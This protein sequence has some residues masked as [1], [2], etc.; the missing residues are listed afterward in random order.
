MKSIFWSTVMRSIVEPMIV[1]SGHLVAPDVN[2]T[3]LTEQAEVVECTQEPGFAFMALILSGL[4]PLF[5][6]TYLRN[7]EHWLIAT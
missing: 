6:S 7:V 4:S 3:E 1:S 5:R 2:R